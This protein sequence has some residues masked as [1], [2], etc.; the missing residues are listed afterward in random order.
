MKITMKKKL[1]YEHKI[2]RNY[3]L[4]DIKVLNIY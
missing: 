4:K 1:Q 3:K 2:Q